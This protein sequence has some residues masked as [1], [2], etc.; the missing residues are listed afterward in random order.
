[1]ASTIPAA[2]TA[3][4]AGL[5]ALQATTLAG[6]AVYRTGNW[7]ESGEHDLISVLNARDISREYPAAGAAFMTEEYTIPV[8]VEVYRQGDNLQT[9]ETRLWDLVTII[10]GFVLSNGAKLGVAGVQRAHP[11][12][13][14]PP[15]EQ[16]GPSASSE[17]MLLAAGT[18]AIRVTAIV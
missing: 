18:V 1:M 16:S 2:R 5:V 17:D 11:A 14:L 7:K 15:G 12:G 8:A 4:H 9:V 10:E 13:L 6:V 3:L